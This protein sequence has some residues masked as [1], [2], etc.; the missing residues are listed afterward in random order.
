MWLGGWNLLTDNP[1]LR[2]TKIEHGPTTPRGRRIQGGAGRATQRWR[3]RICR[4][5]YISISLVLRYR[6][7]KGCRM[8]AWFVLCRTRTR[9]CGDFH[10]FQKPLFGLGCAPLT[11]AAISLRRRRN[12]SRLSVSVDCRILVARFRVSLNYPYRA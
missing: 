5:T 7:M 4:L 8:A 1:Q 2:S 3:S 6:E 11:L 10:R 9:G 12:S